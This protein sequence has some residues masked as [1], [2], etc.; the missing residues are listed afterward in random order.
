[1]ESGQ[2]A[3]ALLVALALRN[4][5]ETALLFS[6]LRRTYSPGINTGARV[7]VPKEGRG[8][9]RGWGG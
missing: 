3:W 1:M 7:H 4:D 8:P 5:D 9:A 6:A 2:N